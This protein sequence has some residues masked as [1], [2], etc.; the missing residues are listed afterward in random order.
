MIKL[1]G[2]PTIHCCSSAEQFSAPQ[3]KHLESTNKDPATNVHKMTPNE[4]SDLGPV[5][6]STHFHK[7][8][9]NVFTNLINAHVFG[10]AE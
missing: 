1:H 2:P 7:K 10:R 8:W 4:L 6:V 5:T 9:H 3:I